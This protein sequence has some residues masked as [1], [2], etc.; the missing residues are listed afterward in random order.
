VN[1]AD[2]GLRLAY[3]DDL[4]VY[5]RS[6]GLP[7]FRWTG[8][9]ITVADDAARLS[10]LAAGGGVTGGTVLLSEDAPRVRA[11]PAM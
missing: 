10:R 3:I 8:R 1:V 5:Q 4:V 2:N 6:R 11:T 9:A 7:R